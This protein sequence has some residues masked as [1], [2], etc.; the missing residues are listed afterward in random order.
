[1][2]VIRGWINV[3]ICVAG[4]TQ[5]FA[6]GSNVVTGIVADN[7]WFYLACSHALNPLKLDTTKVE[8]VLRT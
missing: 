2:R 7:V 5:A 6:S 3:P 4:F 8:F 1:M